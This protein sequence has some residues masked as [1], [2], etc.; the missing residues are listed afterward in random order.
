MKNNKGYFTASAIIFTVIAAAHLGR[1]LFMLD[2]SVGGYEIPLWVSGAA[3]IVAGYLA[4]RGFL[5]AHKL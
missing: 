3:V 5:A 2:A 1:I 4:I